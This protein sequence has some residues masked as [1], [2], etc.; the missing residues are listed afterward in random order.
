VS[1][2]ERAETERDVLVFK[3]GVWERARPLAEKHLASGTCRPLLFRE[4]GHAVLERVPGPVR[5]RLKALPGVVGV[6]PERVLT[7]PSVTVSSPPRT[8]ILMDDANQSWALRALGLAPRPLDGAGITI[9]LIDSGVNLRHPALIGSVSAGTADGGL[10]ALGHGTH[11]AGI[12]VGRAGNGPRFGIAP[13]AK[14]RSYRLF[15]AR[16]EASEGSARDLVRRAAID[17]CRVIVLAAGVTA[18]TFSSEDEQLGRWLALNGRIMVAAAGNESNRLGELVRPTLAPANA[19]NIYAIGAI[20]AGVRLWNASNGK[21]DHPATRVDAVA[22][23]VEVLSAWKDG[24]TLHMSGSSVSTA[25]A[26]GVAAVIWSRRPALSA[27]Q[28]SGLM[29]SL[30]WRRVTGDPEGIGAGSLSLSA[31]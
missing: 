9:G 15:G 22:P 14:I 8:T 29:L 7:R 17:G 20:T 6:R 2:A 5:A 3:P 30:A 31:F 25:V 10:D 18:G 23:G 13:A 27:A 24:R 19:P 28:V 11:C 12:L 26:G 21:G 1:R 4:T 16:D